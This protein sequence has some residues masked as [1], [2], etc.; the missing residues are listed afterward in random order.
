M[1]DVF[2]SEILGAI[3]CTNPSSIYGVMLGAILDVF[4]EAILGI[5]WDV[6]LDVNWDNKFMALFKEPCLA[7]YLV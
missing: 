1:S 7:L 4:L 3:P 6:I 5:T 2:P